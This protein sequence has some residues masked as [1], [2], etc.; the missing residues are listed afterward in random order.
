MAN[1]FKSNVAIDVETT[2][3]VVYT[4]PAATETTLIGMTLSNKSNTTTVTAN[5][6]L[7]R[8]TVDYSI[9]S[10]ATLPVGSALVPVGGDQKIV[11]QPAD[12][13]KVVVS[14]NNAVDVITSLLEIS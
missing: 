5:V 12:E 4:C 7:T 14:T 1:S 9:I 2:G 11:L 3:N 8:S 13:I 6:F 10:N